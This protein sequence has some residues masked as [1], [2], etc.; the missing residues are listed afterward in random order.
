MNTQKKLKTQE[1]IKTKNMKI[2]SEGVFLLAIHPSTRVVESSGMPHFL[3][4][5]FH[6][7]IHNMDIATTRLNRPRAQ[8]SENYPFCFIPILQ[9]LDLY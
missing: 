2:K 7:Y 6:T 3:G 9:I 1:I 8:F 5:V 4:C